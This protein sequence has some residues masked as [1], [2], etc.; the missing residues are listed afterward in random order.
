MSVIM[1]KRL[2]EM[3]ALELVHEQWLAEI[4][5]L[6]GVEFCVGPTSYARSMLIA[7]I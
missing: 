1:S 7:E 2:L 5:S 4:I 3:K 6:M